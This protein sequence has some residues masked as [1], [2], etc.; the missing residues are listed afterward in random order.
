MSAERLHALAARVSDRKI[1]AGIEVIAKSLYDPDVVATIAAVGRAATPA[2]LGP[3][4]PGALPALS[5]PQTADSSAFSGSFVGQFTQNSD[6]GNPGQI[7]AVLQ[8][9]GT[10]VWGQYTI[11]LG[12]GAIQHG[13]VNGE[14]LFFEWE[15]AGNYGRGVRMRLMAEVGL[16]ARGATASQR[17]MPAPGRRGAPLGTEPGHL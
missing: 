14:A 9:N 12:I 17:T 10:T 15:Y 1:A 2:T 7:A 13:K 4:R 16:L 8:R 3:R 11:G 6:P 5:K